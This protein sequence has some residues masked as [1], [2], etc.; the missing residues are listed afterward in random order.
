MTDERDDRGELLP[1]PDRL[2]QFG[3]ALR[4]YRIDEM[5]ELFHIVAGQMSFV[6]PR[7]LPPRTIETMGELGRIRTSVRPGLTGWAQ[8]KGNT[9]LNNQE[10][11]AL[12]AW[13]VKNQSVALDFRILV[14][15]IMTIVH[16]EHRDE[17]AIQ[18]AFAYER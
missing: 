3:A 2:T 7:P 14:L 17:C 9:L 15:T 16:G 6:G 11:A 10:K 5:P 13:Y 8:V 18:L 4:R 12:D 1:D